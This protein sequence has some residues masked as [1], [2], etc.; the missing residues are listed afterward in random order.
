MPLLH[1]GSKINERWR[2]VNEVDSSDSFAFDP[3][4]SFSSISASLQEDSISLN[5][6]SSHPS[7]LTSNDYE[8][9]NTD[10][11]IHIHH[12]HHPSHPHS[13]HHHLAP[14]KSSFSTGDI[15]GFDTS[16]MPLEPQLAAYRAIMSRM[17]PFSNHV[18]G[19][20]SPKRF[21]KQEP[22]LTQDDSSRGDD[23]NSH[24]P[25]NEQHLSSWKQNETDL[26][27]LLF[28]WSIRVCVCVLLSIKI[29]F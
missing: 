22:V 8:N 1:I 18:N 23:S 7:T 20:H 9:I 16:N 11:D 26:F 25:S 17:V 15:D 28:L 2:K 13:S 19:Q 3:S 6:S 4:A 21:I 29:L 24:S 27:F 12:H 14:R 10:D 5:N